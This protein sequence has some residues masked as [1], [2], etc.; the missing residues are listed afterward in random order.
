VIKVP[1]MLVKPFNYPYINFPKIFSSLSYISLY[2]TF[3]NC[4]I[5]LQV[6]ISF[7]RFERNRKLLLNSSPVIDR[8]RKNLPMPN[9]YSILCKRVFI[10]LSRRF[11]LFHHF[12][13]N[14]GSFFC[15]FV[16]MNYL[17]STRC[18]SL[19]DITFMKSTI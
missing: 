11:L 1:N 6:M 18:C 4:Y 12:L 5:I 13:L 9:Y 17:V 15:F 19:S 2:K 8:V 16:F 10:R 14:P 7:I 3:F